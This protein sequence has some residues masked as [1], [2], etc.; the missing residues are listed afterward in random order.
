M[1]DRVAARLAARPDILDQ[2]R[3]SARHPFG[4]IKQWMSQG[5]FPMRGLQNVRGE[6]SLAALAHNI[7]RAITLVGIPGLID[8]AKA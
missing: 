7:R 3:R 5:A 4:R 8:A 1:L 6:F 2:R